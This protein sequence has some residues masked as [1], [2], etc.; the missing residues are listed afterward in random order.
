[1][2]IHQ[3]NEAILKVDSIIESGHYKSIGRKLMCYKSMRLL[4]F[5]GMLFPLVANAG[6]T[7]CK[8]RYNLK[9]WSVIYK[10]YKGAGTIT[11]KNG[12]RANVSIVTR[13]GGLTIGKSEIHKGK[14]AFSDVKN[15]Q[16]I[17]GT[18]I[19]LD[20]HAGATKSVEAQVMTKGEVSLAIYGTGRGMDLGISIGAFT[21]KPM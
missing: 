16:E 2:L 11:C 18:Y 14:G 8:L 9:G 10:Q 20:S 19:A 4:I 15:L 5:M 12:Q 6:M 3:L 1:M 17:Y 7:S 21:I 13:G